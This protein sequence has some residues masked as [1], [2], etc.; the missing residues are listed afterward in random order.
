MARPTIATKLYVPTRRRGL[1]SRPRL[2]ERLGRGAESRLTLVSA[3]AGFGKTT[4]LAEWLDE[5]PIDETPGDRRVAWLSL[6]PADH[7]PATF[8]TYVV[9]ALQAA[10]PGVGPDALELIE[11][12]PLPTERVV[13]TL[14]N[15]LAAAPG[16][17]WLVLDDYHLVDGGDIRDGMAQLLEHLPP[18]VH[19][20]ISTRADPDLPLPRW[21]VRGELVEIRA[22]DLRFTPE[23]AAAYL[24][25]VAGLD[26]APPDVTALEGR[27]EGWI[28][29]LQLAA[30]SIKGRADVGGFIA[31]FAGTDRYVV[32]YLVEEVLAHQPDPI[33]DFL[34]HS[35]V[36]DRLTGSLC[37]AVTGREDGNQMLITLERANLFLVPL[38][39]RREWFRYHHLFADVL[40]ARL[41]SGQP[42]QVPLLHQRASRWYEGQDL[43]EDAVRHALTARDFD[44]AADLVERAVPTL[45][46]HRQDRLLQD[47][48]TALP[49]ATV[50]R[51]PVLSVFYGHLLMASGDLDAV[52]SRLDDAERVLTA[53]AD[54]STRRMSDSEELRTL[55]ATIAVF[56]ASIAQAR[57]DE[58]GTAEQARRALELAGPTD[59]LAR[60]A[61][62]GFLGLA[63]W[64]R[65]E[66][67][68]ALTTFTQAVA[69]LHAA[70]ALVDEL[71]GTV[72]LADL[73]LVA[74]RPGRARRLYRDA[75][76]VADAHGAKVARATVELLVGLSEIDRE[77][78]DLEGARRHLERAG[79]LAERAPMT[80]S[81]YRWFVAMA[82]V[83]DADGDPQ[84]A[85]R[86]L[87][88]AE[89]LYRPGYF[90]DVRPITAMKARVRIRVGD[91]A[92]AADWADERGVSAADDADYLHAFDHLTVVRLLLAQFRATHDRGG[93]DRAAELLDRLADT[94]ETS[95][96]SGDL[97]E[98]RMLRAMTLDAG[99]DRPAALRTLTRAWANAPE[100]DGYARLFLDEGEPMLELLRA[101][102]RPADTGGRARLLLGLTGDREASGGPGQRPTGPSPAELSARERQVLRLLDS[103]LTGPEIA[104]ELFVSQNTVRTHTK[105]IF[106]KLDV[107]NRRAA[108]RRAREL[109]LM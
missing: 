97:L 32:D 58:P 6:D 74:G 75:L 66:V 109:G 49:D 65:G 1:V 73:W 53:A 86:L 24:N 83:A 50:R 38:D 29:A 5:T 55:P 2:G 16:E 62:A 106:T 82:R 10:V 28:A 11:V 23:E 85:I 79:T 59:H 18:H 102:A 108:V 36:L 61:A 101:A 15:E 76:Q 37:D 96:R 57:G 51:R 26:L 91:L 54:D 87:D 31:R 107:T 52:E 93:L 25:E 34:L 13:T 90:P 3:P 64:A 80:E 67:T 68:T 20:V 47:W 103:E 35:A 78:G 98:I 43:M 84:Q 56:R 104:R 39:D 60:G 30:L 95:G 7:E 8:W 70:G 21:R 40:R 77:A 71:S 92:S 88:Q 12:S 72:I 100:P 48:L 17:V 69:S 94:A 9:T 42:E 41:L 105:H 33:R 63:A 44:R 27:T 22:A 99:G 19:V 4:L 89:R 14:L 46:L 81:R 45:R